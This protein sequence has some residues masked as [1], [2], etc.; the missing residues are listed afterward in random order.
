VFRTKNNV[1]VC[2]R[3][4]FDL[5]GGNRYG[6]DQQ[7]GGLRRHIPWLVAVVITAAALIALAEGYFA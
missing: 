1:R 3:E 5:T 7:Q 6:N 4:G 2:N